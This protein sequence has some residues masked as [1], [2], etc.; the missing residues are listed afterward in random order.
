[1]TA[2][3]ARALSTSVQ[4]C[5]SNTEISCK[6]RGFATARTL[7]AASL[8]CAAGLLGG[9]LAPLGRPRKRGFTAEGAKGTRAS[10]RRRPMGRPG[11]KQ[12][13]A[14]PAT[15]LARSAGG[16]PHQSATQPE[17]PQQPVRRDRPRWARSRK[18][19]CANSVSHSCIAS[20][21]E[22]W[23]AVPGRVTPRLRCRHNT[24]V[25]LQSSG[26]YRA[27]GSSLGFVDRL[28]SV[29]P[30]GES[31]SIVVASVQVLLVGGAMQR[32]RK[33]TH[34][35]ALGSTQTT[36]DRFQVVPIVN[37]YESLPWSRRSGRA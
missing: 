7:S 30:R 36:S 13:G 1:M 23:R 5:R 4:F 28:L 37:T 12:R 14:T 11:Q 27:L 17:C 22:R 31:Y 3:R 24:G 19:V 21:A 9:M 16:V 18:V 2:Y 35:D 10:P 15:I 32:A 33:A 20:R 8:C 26:V 29:E 6:G 34:Q 25:K